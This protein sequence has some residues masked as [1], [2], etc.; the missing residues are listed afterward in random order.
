MRV[1]MVGREISWNGGDTMA[2]GGW[3]TRGSVTTTQLLAWQ[4]RHKALAEELQ[5]YQQQWFV[6][7]ACSTPATKRGFKQ[8]GGEQPAHQCS[9]KA[10]L[11]RF[12]STGSS[13]YSF[14]PQCDCSSENWRILV[15]AAS[16][17]VTAYK[18]MISYSTQKS[19]HTLLLI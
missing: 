9:G 6:L 15:H 10:A 11:H 1:E 3:F 19:S 18:E 14:L 2:T 5:N 17:K 16:C 13:T 8:C 7:P 12:S 4:Y